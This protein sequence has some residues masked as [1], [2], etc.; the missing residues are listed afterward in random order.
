MKKSSFFILLS[1]IALSCEFGLTACSS[2]NEEAVDNPNYDPLTK[3]VNAKFV[4]SV[5]TGNTS[6]ATRQSSA[7]TQAT[8]REVFRGIDE[9]QLHAFGLVDNGQYVTSPMTANAT[10]PLGLILDSEALDPD[11]NGLDA[12]GEGVPL[13][14]KVLELALPTGTNTLMFWGK[15]KKEKTSAEEG[16]ISRPVLPISPT[17]LSL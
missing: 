1:M 8:S 9:A 6:S 11:G 10:Y 12:Q 13:S 17:M 16:E 3:T 2:S 14:H 4:F 15:A 7:S 5:S